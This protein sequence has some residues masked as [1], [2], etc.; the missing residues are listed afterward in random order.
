MPKIIQSENMP[1]QS[2]TGWSI[3]T[4][5]NAEEIGFPAMVARWWVIEAGA[6]APEHQR[7]TSDE[8]LYVIRGTGKAQVGEQVFEL[9]DECV[10]WLDEGECVQFVAG[11][12]GLEIL[13]GYAPGEA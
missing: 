5:A 12:E 11:E 3:R 13:Q 1:E 4:I 6:Q 9:D 8:L 10:L 7:G 2:G